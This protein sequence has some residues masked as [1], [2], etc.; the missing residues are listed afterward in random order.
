[1]DNQLM[2]AR[3][4]I[5]IVIGV[6]GFDFQ[7]QNSAVAVFLQTLR[8]ELE[9]TG[10]KVNLI[11]FI[12][13][14][15]AVAPVISGGIVKKVKKAIRWLS[16]FLAI[17]MSYRSYFQAQ[18]SI[19]SELE[20][21]KNECD[22]VIEFLTYGSSIG[23]DFK[24]K[25]NKKLLVIF[26]SPLDLQF[27]EMHGTKSIHF[28]RIRNSEKES[29]QAADHVICYSEAVKQFIAHEFSVQSPVSVVPCIVWKGNVSRESTNELLI[30]FI[31]SFLKWHKVEILVQAFSLIANEFPAARLILIGKGE[32]WEKIKALCERSAFANRITLT[33]FV[34]D[35]ELSQW[36]SKLTIGV[37]PG[38]NWYGSPLK[39]FEYAES[40]IPMI[41]PS[42]PTVNDFFENGV[43]T[44]MIDPE[45]E[46]SSLAGHLRTLLCNPALADSISENARA[47]MNG[48]FSKEQVISKFINIVK[49]TLDGSKA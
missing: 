21:Y 1:M 12:E 33:G 38:T 48:K 11:P 14:A 9:M 28:S 32:E 23:A 46:I 18:K 24:K 45:N 27:L 44:L 31:G 16:P 8:K 47:L 49:N 39:L 41:A 10:F 6:P 25:H 17:S 42:S 7:N 29:I 43:H 19:Y 30:G 34:G 26:D 35:H 40:G 22:L 3:P 20:K 36:K 15:P 2:P 37:M 5:C 13:K 4:T